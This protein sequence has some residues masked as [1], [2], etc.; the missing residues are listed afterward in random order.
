M[1]RILCKKFILTVIS[2]LFLSCGNEETQKKQSNAKKHSSQ[3][4]VPLKNTGCHPF[5]YR[6][7]VT[8]SESYESKKAYNQTVID[9]NTRSTSS[10]H[11]AP[12]AVALVSKNRLCSGVLIDNETIL[13]AAHCAYPEVFESVVLSNDINKNTYQNLKKIAEVCI[14][15]SYTFEEEIENIDLFKANPLYDIAWVKISEPPV[16]KVT[17]LKIFKNPMELR[18]G[19]PF[20]LFGYGTLKK[21]LY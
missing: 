9:Q 12:Y 2:L 19:T 8:K 6:N 20:S 1:K 4:I 18:E 13:T 11:L 17:N 14:H 15:P 16:F 10:T 7:P 5:S 21:Q 3:N